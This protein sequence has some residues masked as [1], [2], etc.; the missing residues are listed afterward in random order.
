MTGYEIVRI[1]GVAMLF[2]GW[3]LYTIDFLAR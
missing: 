2:T 3:L 1:I